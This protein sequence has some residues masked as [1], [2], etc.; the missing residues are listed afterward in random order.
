MTRMLLAAA[1]V[2]VLATTG[3]AGESFD[4]FDHHPLGRVAVYRKPA[5]SCALTGMAAWREA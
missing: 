4:L 2:A 1:I 5:G 3:S